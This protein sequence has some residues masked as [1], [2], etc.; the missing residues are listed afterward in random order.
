MIWNRSYPASPVRKPAHARAWAWLRG[1]RLRPYYSRRT[2]DGV[3]W[4]GVRFIYW[5]STSCYGMPFDDAGFDAA[6]LSLQV[7]LVF[8]SVALEVTFP[9][10]LS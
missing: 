7:S 3:V 8:A 10:P 2:L 5:P 9:P 1:F 4:L 6:S